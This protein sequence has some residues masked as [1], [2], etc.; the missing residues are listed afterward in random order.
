M[1]LK[2][3]DL[4]MENKSRIKEIKYWIKAVWA[5]IRGQEIDFAVKQI[6]GWFKGEIVSQKITNAVYGSDV[7]MELEKD[8]D[9]K[10]T[11]KLSRG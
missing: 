6:E 1:A 2:Q 10:E 5:A 9:K 3:K 7:F 8:W 4:I 11:A